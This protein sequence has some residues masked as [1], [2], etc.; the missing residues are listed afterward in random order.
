LLRELG[1]WLGLERQSPE[2]WLQEGVRAESAGDPVTAER[3]YRKAL[4]GDPNGA[5]PAHLLGS[6]LART[7]R[8][9]EAQAALERALAAAP[10]LAE[11]HADMGNIHRLSNN[12][13]GAMESYQ[14]AL[15]IKH[16]DPVAVLGLAELHLR[17]NEPEKAAAL[18]GPNPTGEHAERLLAAACLLQNRYDQAASLYESAF[19][20]NPSPDT[21]YYL[22]VAYNNSGRRK[23]A[24]QW[25]QATLGLDKGHFE[26]HCALGAIGLSENDNEMA[27]LHYAAAVETR[28]DAWD[29][30]SNLGIAF[31]RTGRNEDAIDCFQLAHHFRPGVASTWH[32]EGLAQHAIG[33]HAAARAC[34]EKALEQQPGSVDL[35]ES[36]AVTYQCE[37]RFEEAVKKHLE[38]LAIEPDRQDVLN[39]LGL[40]FREMGRFSESIE[41]LQE[42]L[43]VAPSSLSTRSNLGLALRDSGD[44]EG[45]MALFDQVLLEDPEFEDAR[46]SASVTRLFLGDYERGW[47]DYEKRWTRKESLQR[48]FRFPAWLGQPLTGRSLLVFGEQG[49]GDQIMFASCL[50]E[51]IGEARSVVVECSTRLEKLFARSFPAADV[52]GSDLELA[53]E[54]PGWM[55]A[56]PPFD[57][58]IAIGSLP[59]HFRKDRE[60]FP[61]HEGYLKADPERV[62]YWRQRLA[63]LGPGTKV[64]IS[65]QGGAKMT[66]RYLRSMSPLE[67]AGTVARVGAHCISLQYTNCA[68][69]LES[70]RTEHGIHV[71]HWEEAIKDY[72]ETAAL[73]CAL[74]LVVSVCTSVIHLTGALGRPLIVMAPAAPEWRYGRSGDGMP[75]YPSAR[76][77][78]QARAG[79][80]NDVLRQVSESIA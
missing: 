45:A 70:L 25:F 47:E 1:K 75:W 80:W 63:Q 40:A 7:G 58:Q 27:Q 50:G 37:G 14:S 24:R 57:F 48:P 72:D 11:L 78:R 59:Y 6:L 35:L 18:L 55:K 67:L 62:A 36:L 56:M 60:S 34:F 31:Y 15:R 19:L 3:C 43:L 10:Q 4:R 66:R 76:L 74:D 53:I 38:A 79:D 29:A 30:H 8:L 32:N 12:E 65:W 61:R 51:V 44:V 52:H 42:S 33:K 77:I 71:H 41:T 69:D 73:V 21:A 2:D 49:L 26:S 17:R 46:W 13:A 16:D 39:N 28:H 5:R 68:D 54:I 9:A 22:G 64:G 23:E 20:K